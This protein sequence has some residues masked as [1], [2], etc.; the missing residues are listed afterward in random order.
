MSDTAPDLFSFQRHPDEPFTLETAVYQAIGAATTCWENLSGTGVFDSQRADAIGQA[1]LDAIRELTAPAGED[2][3]ARDRR[4]LYERL[5][6]RAGDPLLHR[7]GDLALIAEAAAALRATP[8]STD[9]AILDDE[10]PDH[11]QP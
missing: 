1:L 2:A 8:T 11:A 5:R 9:L 3:A 7:P 6:E 4:T 10:E